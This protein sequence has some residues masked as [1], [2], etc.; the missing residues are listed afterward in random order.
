MAC[1]QCGFELVA[2]GESC[3]VCGAET[4][5]V[6]R[7]EDA[8]PT[9]QQET[10]SASPIPS[11]PYRAGNTLP[12][13]SFFT[14]NY[15]VEEMVGRG[16]MGTVY[17]VLDTRDGRIRA[18]KLL[19][20]NG[21][22]LDAVGRFKRE[23]TILSRLKHPA[24]PSIDEWGVEQEKMYFAG[25][26]VEGENL[27]R[28]Q[29][30]RGVLTVEEARRI[31]MTVAS[32]LA[33]AHALGVVHRDVKPHNIMLTPENAT[34]LLD[35]GIARGIG[36]EMKAITSTG[37]IVGT[38]EYMSPEQFQ[39]DRVDARSDI[40]SLGVVLYELL[41]GAPPF[42]SDSAV[43]L[44]MKHQNELPPPIRSHR[45]GVPAWLER[46][47]YRCLAKDPR[48]RFFTADE[49]VEELS[50]SRG[51]EKRTRLLPTGDHV[52]E[53]DSES[54]HYALV[55]SSAKQRA[56]WSL[57]MAMHFEQRYYQLDDIRKANDRWL[58][59]FSYWP[60][61][62]IFRKVIDYDAEAAAP[63]DSG[64]SSKLRGWFKK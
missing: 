28:V 58:Y 63:A 21:A 2:E 33:A 61:E 7:S 55:I 13:G 29:R 25:D 17:K 9:V 19:H 62:R 40:Y 43:A 3:A 60:E 57:G 54:E 6:L 26:F 32:A 45:A 53:D 50:R 4:S 44:G 31:G 11:L 12:S 14:P 5:T 46:A 1:L 42:T 20:A 47:V 36:I 15:R 39:G 8:A 27:R 22:D 64:L 16:G 30:K 56:N 51:G 38:P 48:E 23:I 37:M 59:L 52:V 18:L 10:P 49:L 35:F 34:R 24:I 41:A